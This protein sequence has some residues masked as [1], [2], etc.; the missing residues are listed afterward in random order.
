[1]VV[2]V[3]DTGVNYNHVDLATCGPRRRHSP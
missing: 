2:G 3:V 1:V